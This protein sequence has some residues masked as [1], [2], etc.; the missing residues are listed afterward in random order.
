MNRNIPPVHPR[1]YP[2]DIPQEDNQDVTKD[3]PKLVVHRLTAEAY[4]SLE[5]AVDQPHVRSTTTEQQVSFMLGQQH[6][7]KLLRD[8]F[9]VGA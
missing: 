5:Q 3:T 1:L 6:V 9:V 2:P 4:R 7:L 8:G